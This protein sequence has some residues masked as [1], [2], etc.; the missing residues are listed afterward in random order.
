M[1]IA[2]VGAG[3]VGGTL[4]K[5]WARKGHEVIWGVRNP[6]DADIHKLAK[7]AGNARATSVRDAAQ[8]ADIVVLTVP[9]DAVPDAIRNAGDLRGKIVLDCTNPLRPDL[10]GLTVGQTSSAAEQVAAAAPNAKVV[11]IFNT[12]GA[13][14]MADPRYPAGNLTMFYCGDDAEAKKAA[15]TLASDLGFEPVDAGDLATARLLEPLAMLWIQLALKQG[16]GGDFGFKLI[17]R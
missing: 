17:R 10:S 3:N 6:S 9:Y 1:R 14:N 16:W 12:T 7:E 15:A 4:D 2:I 8:A 11:K 13:S 5:A